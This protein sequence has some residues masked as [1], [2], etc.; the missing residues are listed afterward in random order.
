MK[1][2]K[3]F[4]SHLECSYHLESLIYFQ[5]FVSGLLIRSLKQ[6]STNHGSLKMKVTIPLS[7]CPIT[8]RQ[9]P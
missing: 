6:I 1:M 7:D 9:I 8:P 2:E 3:I 4:G 5:Y